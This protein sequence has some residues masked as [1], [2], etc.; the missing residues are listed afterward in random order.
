MTLTQKAVPVVQGEFQI[1]DDPD[2]V[3]TT[4]LGS[5]VSVCLHDAMAKVGGMNHFLLPGDASST[6]G[7]VKYGVNAMELLIN[8]LLKRGATRRS[9][10]A[11]VFGACSMGM[12]IRNIGLSNQEFALAFLD[13]EGIPVAGSSL[14]G[15]NARR[16]RF[17]P[18]TGQ[19]Q[20]MVV[21]NHDVVEDISAPL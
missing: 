2:V 7:N 8:G 19:V 10:S 13:R 1:S 21:P 6:S 11:K 17:R 18:A 16:V 14:G 5:C 12:S 15:T 20:Q 9:L 4:I 3:F